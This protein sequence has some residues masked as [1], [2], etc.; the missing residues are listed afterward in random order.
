M[1][2]A[3]SKYEGLGND[4]VIVD[5]RTQSAKLP[6]AAA[7]A[8]E[9]CDRHR[10]IG[11][12]G[13]LL[14]EPAAAGTPDGRSRQAMRVINAD[15]SRPEMC[16]NGIRC[17]ALHLVRSGVQPVGVAFEI[18]T[19]SGPH[20]CRVVSRERESAVQVSMRAAE[21]E[22]A[23]I[24]VLAER[25]VLDEPFEA[26]GVSLRLSCVSMGNP[27]AV[28]F[29][30]LGA[31]ARAALGPALEKHARFPRA[32]NIGFARIVAPQV[33]ELAVW[34]R[35]VGFTQACGTGAC[36]CAVAA[37]ETGRAERHRAIEI[38]LPGGALQILVGERGDAISMTGPARHVFDGSIEG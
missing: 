1:S 7:R 31:S 13:V 29:D 15:G 6:I 9:I 12:D 24:P 18:D 38:R 37:V 11:A 16:G 34:E 36:A 10:G 8:V 30:D 35:G 27:H 17:V 21:L 22:P 33:I 32:A 23:A 26:A 19:D 2:I 4:F 14:I 5:G 20:V 25:I 28:T 3:F